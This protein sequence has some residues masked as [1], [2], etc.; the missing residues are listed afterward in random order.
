MKRS[1]K[2][3]DGRLQVAIWPNLA[4]A[5]AG[6]LAR[7]LAAWLD[8]QGVEVLVPEEA[9]GTAPRAVPA[10]VE[11]WAGRA[12]FAM[13]LGG[14][15]TLLKAARRLAPL[16]LPILGVNLGHLGFLT[17][18]DAGQVFDALPAF[19]EGR[20]IVDERGTVEAEVWRADGRGAERYT[21]LNDAVVSVGGFAR[22]LHLAVRV[23]NTPLATYPADGVIIATPTGSTAYSLA[24]G[25]PV[26]SPHLD[27]VVVTPICAHTFYARP[28]VIDRRE[29]VAVRVVS[30]GRQVMLTVDG[31][32]CCLLQPGDEVRVSAGRDVVRL[33]RR[34]GWNFY[35]VLRRKFTEPFGSGST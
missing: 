5:G 4:K 22:L 19:L 29:T 20:C 16:G 23:G 6:E 35:E 31:Q 10:P 1:V 32:E 18:V 11:T 13:V 14:D 17:E 21:V 12:T 25:G 27:V 24:A 9:A 34:P 8:E 3:G 2:G 33:L 7:S 30:E 26:L 15:G 28:T